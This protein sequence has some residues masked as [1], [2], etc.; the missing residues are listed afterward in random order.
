M[1]YLITAIMMFAA[2]NQLSAQT[3]INDSP[4]ENRAYLRVGIEPTT[5]ITFG[6]QRNFNVGF[7]N[8]NVTSYAEWGTSMVRFGFSNSELKIGGIL[9]VFEKGSF[10]VVNN[11][12][13][14]AGSVTT[15]NFDSKKFAAGDEVAVG[16]YKMSW[17]IAT[18]VE[19][20][21]IY[22]N[23]IEHSEFYR[24]TYYEDAEDGWYKGAGGMF[25]FGIEGGGTIK[26]KYDIH[27]EIKMPFTEKF[28]SYGGS[29]FHVNL[30]LG[31]RF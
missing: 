23:R 4:T 2:M 27:L 22:L 12:S 26:G 3:I 24:T 20:E 7:L 17:F 15:K 5:M 31:Y 18:T 9:L 19:Y 29:P 16:F 13:L 14:S 1:K 28:N 21:K 25:Q 10:K 30:G 8:R 6:Y 11:L